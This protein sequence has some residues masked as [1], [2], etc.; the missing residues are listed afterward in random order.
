MVNK[1]NKRRQWVIYDLIPAWGRSRGLD[2]TR[3]VITL[4]AFCF[5]SWAKR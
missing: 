3:R 5:L 2:S 1:L 4:R